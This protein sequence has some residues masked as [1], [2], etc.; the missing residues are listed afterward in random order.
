MKTKILGIVTMVTV[1]LMML[2]SSVNAATIT[3]DKAE[4]AKEEIVTLTV[5]LKEAAKS[6]QFDVEFD[7]DNYTYVDGS[8][9]SDLG[10]TKAA[11]LADKSNVVR[12]SGFALD[13]ETT[14]TVTLQFKA[15][16]N[17]EDLAFTVS[18]TE[19]IGVDGE[20]TAEAFENATITTTIADPVEE[21][22]D[23]TEEPEDPTEK[24][25][26]KPDDEKP[27]EDPDKDDSGYYDE[28][29]NPI[30]KLPQTGSMVPVVVA[31]VAI[32]VVASL[33]VFKATRK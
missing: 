32:L 7:T 19:F 25:D 26:Q 12:V 22:E 30:E 8:V 1:L 3:A 2:V 5:E 29:G 13:G 31:G 24:P 6:V 11:V 18:G 9:K 28:D 23:P 21:P 33:V 10:S 4:M 14:T 15:V 16:E 27:A 20:E 17:G